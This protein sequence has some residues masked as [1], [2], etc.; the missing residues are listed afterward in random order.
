MPLVDRRGS[1]RWRA[2]VRVVALLLLLLSVCGFAADLWL[3]FP[4]LLSSRSWIGWAVGTVALGALW[5]VGEGGGDWISSR[6][7]V[8]HPLWKRLCH[9]A[10]LLAFA[11]AVGAAVMGLI[12]MA[13]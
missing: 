7:R 4:L 8:D 12:R 9:L 3:G 10:L 2:K 11:A 13:Q 5:L 6:D 1:E